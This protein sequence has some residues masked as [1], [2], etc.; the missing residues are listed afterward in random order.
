MSTSTVFTNNQS[1]P[2]CCQ[3]NRKGFSLAL[4]A[5]LLK[6]LQADLA[7]GVLVVATAD[8]ADVQHIAERLSSQYTL[9]GAH[10]A[11]DILHVA[12][13]LHLGVNEFL[14]FDQNQRAL[15]IT[16]GLKVPF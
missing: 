3:D 9:M 12:T 8:W 4:G 10:R 5:M 14:T 13:A 15:A 7:A 6:T 1:R 11:L 2:G 16:E